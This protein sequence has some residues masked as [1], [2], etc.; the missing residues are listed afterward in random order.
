MHHF[1]EMNPL[2]KNLKYQQ[3]KKDIMIGDYLLASKILKTSSDNIR[4]R[5]LRRKEDTLEV[6]QAIIENR[7]DFLKRMGVDT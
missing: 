2:N 1:I 4:Q 6:L 7:K 5:V 3:I